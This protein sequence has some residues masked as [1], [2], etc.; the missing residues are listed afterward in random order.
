MNIKAL[1]ITLLVSVGLISLFIWGNKSREQSL[2]M[3]QDT[4]VACLTFGHTNLAEHI[5]PI[6]Q[7]TVDGQMEEIPA[8][9]GIT[10]DCMAEVHTHD[11]T[12]TLHLESFLPGR[13]SE[14][15]LT[16]FYAVWGQDIEREGYNYEI[17]VDGQKVDGPEDVVF[18][19]QSLIELKYTTI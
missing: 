13:I 4:D 5:H 17:L 19:D 15:D 1:S 8:N 2:V 16:D 10:E 9:I 6:L 3:Y 18:I 12:G 11:K 7:I 14:F